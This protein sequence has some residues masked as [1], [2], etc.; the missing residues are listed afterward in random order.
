MRS[1]RRQTLMTLRLVFLFFGFAVLSSSWC[2]TTDQTVYLE[3][4]K[5]EIDQKTG[6]SKYLGNVK[7]TRG[8]LTILASTMLIFK[9]DETLNRVTAEGDPVK[10][11]KERSAEEKEIRG[12][13]LQLEYDAQKDILELKKEAKLWQE[14]DQFSGDYIQY[15]IQQELVHASKGPSDERVRVII[16]PQSNN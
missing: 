1:N 11:T 6:I 14:Q 3:A 12:Q 16:H 10:F 13:A 7:L 9:T 5:V 8:N 2:Q 15:N 4:D